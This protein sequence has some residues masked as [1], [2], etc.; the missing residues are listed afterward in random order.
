MIDKMVHSSNFNLLSAV[1][2]IPV[3]D[4]I[5]L[6]VELLEG[7]RVKTVQVDLSSPSSH[8]L[9]AFTAALLDHVDY[10]PQLLL[11]QLL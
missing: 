4:F 5:Q 7:L 10:Y 9:V 11:G 6:T 2:L 3:Q 1:D 8:L